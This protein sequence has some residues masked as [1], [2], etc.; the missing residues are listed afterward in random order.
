[1][2]KVEILVDSQK[3][4]RKS[5][6]FDV[7][8]STGAAE[9]WQLRE[10][11]RNHLGRAES[12]TLRVRLD[13]ARYRRL[14]DLDG[15]SDLTVVHVTPRSE[16]AATT[17]EQIP[18]W[19]DADTIVELGLLNVSVPAPRDWSGQSCD[20]KLLSLLNA[21]FVARDI[22][23][24]E[25]LFLLYQ[26]G[27]KISRLLAS[28]TIIN[29]FATILGKKLDPSGIPLIFECLACDNYSAQLQ[30]LF[31]QIFQEKIKVFTTVHDLPWTFDA[32]H[33]SDEITDKLAL[34][35]DWWRAIRPDA[36][37]AQLT[38]RVLLKVN[39]GTISPTQLADVVWTY[40][41]VQLD[42]IAVAVQHDPR[43]AT[44]D[45]LSR[46]SGLNRPETVDLERRVA[47]LLEVVSPGLL[48][49]ESTVKQALEWAN[50]YLAHA[51]SAFR[52][53]QEPDADVSGS[54]SDWV[55]A[56]SDRITLSDHN[57]RSVAATVK[58]GLERGSDVI[59]LVIDAFGAIVSDRL[60]QRLQ[61][62]ADWQISS[63]FL[64]G[65][66]PTI[67][68][69]AKMAV[70]SGLNVAQLLS[71]KEQALRRA[72]GSVLPE[73]EAV[74]FSSSWKDV[75]VTMHDA[76][77]LMVVFENQFDEQVHQCITYAD[78]DAQLEV[79]CTKVSNS[80]VRWIKESELRDRALEIYI[81]A[82]HGMARIVTAMDVP[83]HQLTKTVKER[84]IE[85]D[86]SVTQVPA[87]YYLVT[88]EGSG[89]SKYI[90]PRGRVK[91]SKG[92]E[93]FVHGGLCP[94]EVLIPLIGIRRSENV[95]AADV[96]ITA[97]PGE[98]QTN[99]QGWSLTLKVTA[100]A[101]H[102]RR[103]Q[104]SCEAPFTGSSTVEH[105]AEHQSK[106]MT[107][108]IHPTVPQEGW[109]NIVLKV[110]HVLIG[111]AGFQ[112]SQQT[113]SVNLRPHILIREQGAA[114][115]DNMFD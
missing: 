66:L 86:G 55:D 68:E 49:P 9:L 35:D 33:F 15:M 4:S 53:E 95:Q 90:V 77:R 18:Y 114:D 25:L 38:D 5:M 99:G 14:A 43:L 12:P 39:K 27:K 82:D 34:T 89:K 109:V 8:A 81:T 61:S 98:V 21:R 17:G 103:V 108:Q 113:V 96:R 104:I 67:T 79:V 84:C 32:R 40:S 54:F 26:S 13:D 28:E 83:P 107:M 91:F 74:Q 105:V 115:F 7:Q 65:P 48:V 59:L 58:G 72:Y 23:P 94:E 2:A 93:R 62:A 64:F 11:I 31:R 30:T 102:L 51:R 88:P 97:E 10:R 76:A 56:Q 37:L 3:L 60:V 6:D 100:G 42:K 101:A 111:G 92:I 50:R 57:W 16:L 46:I 47:E 52:R 22:E 36:E 73:A 106:L 80:I 85:V 112:E 41:R 44:Q 70:A 87:D 24:E 69:V 29:H 78:L 63:Q 20:M 1:M 45:L 110:A 75:N 71:D 19:C